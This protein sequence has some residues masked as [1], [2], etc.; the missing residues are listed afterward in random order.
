MIVVETLFRFFDAARFSGARSKTTSVIES[1][2]KAGQM[3]QTSPFLPVFPMNVKA[4][5]HHQRLPA[6]RDL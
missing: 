4:I 2:E 3:R 5:R 6:A 1:G